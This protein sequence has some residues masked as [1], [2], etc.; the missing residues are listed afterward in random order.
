MSTPTNNFIP[1]ITF[2][3]SF[4]INKKGEMIEE[5]YSEFE[6]GFYETY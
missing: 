4:K 6:I 3:Y 2:I 5:K 1:F